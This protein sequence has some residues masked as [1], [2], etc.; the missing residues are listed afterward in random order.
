M[1]DKICLN[2]GKTID[3]CEC[4][5]PEF[6]EDEEKEELDGMTVKGEDGEPLDLLDDEESEYEE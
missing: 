6:E 2:C 5:N 1:A 4:E 3:L